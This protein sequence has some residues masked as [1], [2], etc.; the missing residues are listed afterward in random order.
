MTENN[1]PKGTQAP[2]S[3]QNPFNDEN[4]AEK[5]INDSTSVDE[6]E[7]AAGNT[8]IA[9]ADTK[10]AKL[11]KHLR[12]YWY[13]YVIGNVVFLAIFLPLL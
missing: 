4:A 6:I 1:D 11:K 9:T 10:W 5:G 13:W 12:K 3:Q 2:D 7:N 8:G